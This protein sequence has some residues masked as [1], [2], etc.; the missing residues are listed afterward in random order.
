[1]LSVCMC[2]RFQAD[3][4]EVHLRVVKRIMRYLVY[5]PKFG[6]WYPNG[7]TFDLIGYFYADWAGCK[8]DRKSTSVTCQ[9]L[10]RSLL[11]WASK[12]QNSVALSTTEAEYIV[13]CH[14]CA[15]LLW[16]RQTLRDYGY[17][18]SKV[19]LLCDNES[20]IRMA[21]NPVERSRTKHIDI[22]YHFLRDHQQKGDIEIAYVNTQN[23][24]ADIFTKPLDEKTFSKL[25]NELTILDSQNFERNIAHIAYLY[26][27]DHISFIWYIHIFLIHLVP[28]LR[29]MCFQVYL[30]TKS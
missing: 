13:T 8:V 19:P 27:F 5:A 22:R 30:Y 18:L 11:S 25:R 12:K 21:D 23:Q 29:L 24:L 17:K 9:F 20:A 15:Q 2:A 10:G 6:L 26:T 28:R 7:S 3:P 4:K 16:M 1:M 14:C